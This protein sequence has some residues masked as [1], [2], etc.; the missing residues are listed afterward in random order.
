MNGRNGPGLSSSSSSMIPISGGHH[1]KQR[2]PSPM[3]RDDDVR[4]PQDDGKWKSSE[5]L[6]RGRSILTSR[7]QALN[8]TTH[9]PLISNQS[10]ASRL[11]KSS[12]PS[13]LEYVRLKNSNVPL[14]LSKK[15]MKDS[16]SVR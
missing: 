16:S 10:L 12:R 1:R 14:S 4:R 9:D 13:S 6:L 8:D 5:K 15:K 2:P 7:S 3:T 11:S